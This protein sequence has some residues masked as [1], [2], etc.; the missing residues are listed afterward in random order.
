MTDA[1]RAR[2]PRPAPAELAIVQH[3]HQHL[4]TDGYDNHEGLS[5]VLEAFSTVL[6]LHLRYRVPVNLH[7]SGTLLEAAAWGGPDFFNWV[8]ALRD[9]NL[10]EILGSAYSQPILTLFGP[11][12]NRRQLAEHLDLIHR[13]LAIEPAQVRGFWV[14]ERVWR[15]ERLGQL[16]GDPHLANGGY[17][18]V[19][20]DD[21]VFYPATGGAD[22]QRSRFDRTTRPG[23]SGYFSPATEPDR[24]SSDA[25]AWTGGDRHRRPWRIEGAE[26]LA[27][28]PICGDLRYAIPPRDRAAW[29]LLDGTLA[30]TARAGPGA[31][32]VYADDLEKTAAVGPWTSGSWRR[33]G[34]DTYEALL[35]WLAA[36]DDVETVLLS[37]WLTAHPPGGALAFEPGTFYELAADGAGDDYQRWWGSPAYRPYRGYLESVEGALE[38]HPGPAASGNGHAPAAPRPE[39]GGPENGGR[40]SGAGGLVDLAWKQFMAATY[41][42][43]WHGLGAAPDEVAPWAR[44]CASHARSALVTLAADRW[45]RRPGPVS[46][47]LADLDGDGDDEVVLANSCLFAVLSPRYGARLVALFDLTVPGGRQVV[48]NPADDWNWQEELNRAM[49]VPANH[50]GAFVDVGHDN[51]PWALEALDQ[52][53]GV[54]EARLRQAG[55]GPL[56]G[57]VKRFRLHHDG[58]ALEVTYELTEAAERFGVEFGLSPDYLF[59]VREGRAAEPLGGGRT[60]G[61]AAGSAQVWVDLPSGEPLVWEAPPFRPA[62]HVLRLRVAAWAPTF[63][64]SLGV[65]ALPGAEIDVR[66]VVKERIPTPSERQ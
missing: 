39:T 55:R 13:H 36:T 41:E 27:A 64:L 45:R 38:S 59:L 23:R 16:I 28:V 52:R 3:G 56:A 10:V 42:T 66:E 14:P 2:Q 51:E 15:T 18:W 22:S 53:P 7:L 35:R 62:G 61:F 60:R 20:L 33:E 54:V 11:D 31:L 21:R 29:A 6:A 65:G 5:E 57:S 47:W 44:A 26:G 63:R 24:A 46:A 12:H 40:R 43:A 50:P 32:A 30:A 25:T 19:L 1:T 9:E 34:V 37:P 8:R 48:G 58:A 4:I 17:D 49:E